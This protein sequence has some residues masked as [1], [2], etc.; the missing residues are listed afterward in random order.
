MFLSGFI[1]SPVGTMEFHNLLRELEKKKFLD[2][3]TFQNIVL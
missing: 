2:T 1:L 3:I